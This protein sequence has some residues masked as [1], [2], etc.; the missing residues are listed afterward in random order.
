MMQIQDLVSDALHQPIAAISYSVNRQLAAAFAEQFVLETSNGYFSLREYARAGHCQLSLADSLHPELEYNWLGEE[1]G[2][3]AATIR[4]AWLSVAWQEQQLSV[5]TMTWADGGGCESEHHWVV[6]PSREAA[7]AF[8]RAVC[9]W[10]SEIRDEILVFEEGGWDKSEELFQAIKGADFDSLVLRG[11]L[12]HDI[13]ADASDFFAAEATYRTYGVPWKRGILLIGPPG[14]GKTHMVKALINRL[15]KPCLY[16]KSF[17]A[18]YSTASSNMQRAFA[19]AR[20]VAPCVLVLEDLDALISEQSR[21]FFL[22]EVDGFAANHGILL[23]ATTNHPER[24]DAA[25]LNRPSRFDRKYHFALPETAE[26]HAY[27]ARWNETLPPDTRLSPAGL[28]A[29]AERSEGFSFA[30]LKELFLTALMAWVGTPQ[31]G[32]MDAAMLAQIDLLREQM[33]SPEQAAG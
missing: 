27:I 29:A 15:E 6:A 21:S 13:L 20:Q 14:N 31:S 10:N 8:F 11:T 32:A 18:Q 9:A 4:N 25:I 28:D 12:R 7:E 22:N 17:E 26:R 24:I 19:R 33:I 1:W 2:G 30:Y 16:V 5:L 3:I 23:L